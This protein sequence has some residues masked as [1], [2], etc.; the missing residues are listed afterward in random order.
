MSLEKVSKQPLLST[1]KSF[2]NTKV[3]GSL[4]AEYAYTAKVPRDLTFKAGDVIEVLKVKDN[5]DW[6]LGTCHRR[7]GLFPINYMEKGKTLSKLKAER[8]SKISLNSFT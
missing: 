6:W 3:L 7:K 2:D 8:D 4:T 5:V 1:T